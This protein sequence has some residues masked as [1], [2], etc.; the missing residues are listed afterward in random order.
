MLWSQVV[1]SHPGAQPFKLEVEVPEG[2]VPKEFIRIDYGDFQE[3][4]ALF[5][6]VGL[7]HA[8]P[9]AFYI[10]VQLWAKDKLTWQLGDPSTKTS[11]RIVAALERLSSYTTE[12]DTGH[13]VD[14]ASLVLERVADD[15]E[16][17]N[18]QVPHAMLDLGLLTLPATV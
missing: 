17:R 12:E 11:E 6:L 15:L 5:Q 7:D 10:R 1:L 9:Q 8:T 13:I 14:R 18:L 4:H 2:Q 16:A 3:D